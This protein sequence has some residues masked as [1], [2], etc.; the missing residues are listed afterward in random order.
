[1][2]STSP[3]NTFRPKRGSVAWNRA[4]FED[5]IEVAGKPGL[6]VHPRSVATIPGL[7]V[8]SGIE[9]P[10]S[11]APSTMPLTLLQ[12]QAIDKLVIQSVDWLPGSSPW[13][14]FTFADAAQMNQVGGYWPGGSKKRSCG[15]PRA[16][17]HQ[18]MDSTREPGSGIR[19]LRNLPVPRAAVI[20]AF[21]VET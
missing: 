16:T 20:Q 18:L 6:L 3:C 9:A 11:Y 15:L 2:P 1:M 5:V 14:S 4:N 10:L 19:I 21:L 12:S 7:L 17:Y 8:G 13:G